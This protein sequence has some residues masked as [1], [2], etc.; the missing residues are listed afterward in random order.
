M[1]QTLVRID[2]FFNFFFLSRNYPS[3][4]ILDDK[5]KQKKC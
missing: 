4:G 3:G 2:L 1:D 5:K